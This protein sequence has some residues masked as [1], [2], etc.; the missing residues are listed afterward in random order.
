M[1]PKPPL[2]KVIHPGAFR[3]VQDWG[4]TGHSEPLNPHGSFYAPRGPSFLQRLPVWVRLTE[5]K[6]DDFW[7][8]LG[9]LSGS[10]DEAG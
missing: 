2:Q 3:G 8:I 10:I 4:L 7:G 5:R 1:A 9:L 6:P